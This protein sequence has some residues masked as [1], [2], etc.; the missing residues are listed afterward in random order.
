MNTGGS[1][2]RVYIGDEFHAELQRL[3]DED[4]RTLGAEVEWLISEELKRRPQAIGDV[5][6]QARKRAS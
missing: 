2:K 3:A 1:T 6:P 5:E 4:H